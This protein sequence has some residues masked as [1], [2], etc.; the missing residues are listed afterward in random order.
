MPSLAEL[1]S[2][3]RSSVYQNLHVL[4]E[5]AYLTK[6]YDKTYR[7]RGQPASYGLAGRGLRYLRDSTQLNQTVLR[8]M[9]KNKTISQDH[10]DHCLMTITVFNAFQRPAKPAFD[11]FSRYEI[12]DLEF[13]PR[14]LPDLYLRRE[15]PQAG[16][17]S[18]YL[19]DIFGPQLPLWVMKQR[20][21]A[22]QQACDESDLDDYPSVLLVAPNDRIENK[23]LKLAENLLD[24]FEI[25]TT[26]LERLTSPG[27]K[28]PRIWRAPFD[29][30]VDWL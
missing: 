1:W 26:T 20:I 30:V 23:L 24:D 27:D 5:Q 17:P 28:Q 21:R 2:R 8:N 9:Y 3:D 6:R 14:P 16:R 15:R 25:Y 18:G 12:A 10:I 4:V 22:Y 19:L 13:C 7:L 11:T 29:E